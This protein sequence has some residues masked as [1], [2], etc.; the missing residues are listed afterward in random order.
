ML[1]EFDSYAKAK[2]IETHKD[3][4][5]DA[6]TVVSLLLKN[7]GYYAYFFFH[8]G[9][10]AQKYVRA[11]STFEWAESDPEE[12]WPMF[13]WDEQD[14]VDTLDPKAVWYD[15]IWSFQDGHAYEELTEFDEGNAE[16]VME[17]AAGKWNSSMIGPYI[18]RIGEE[19]RCGAGQF[20]TGPAEVL[21]REF[22]PGLRRD[23][24]H[25]FLEHLTG[26]FGK[27]K[28]SLTMCP[29]ESEIMWVP[30]SFPGAFSLSD[31]ELIARVH[32]DLP[33]VDLWKST[34]EQPNQPVYI[35][36]FSELQLQQLILGLLDLTGLSLSL[37]L[38][39]I[40]RYKLKKNIQESI[41]SGK[42]FRDLEADGLR[43]AVIPFDGRSLCVSK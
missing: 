5:P 20:N 15:N 19:V 12:T 34:Q 36:E 24:F 25:S 13:I 40:R 11:E 35:K 9:L 30:L 41:K 22:M 27:R 7:P 8:S 16:Y 6:K 32:K 28:I 26:P 14:R 17:H 38:T 10:W 29:V 1:D 23:I 31:K 4:K 37:N 18:S 42:F 3:F 21:A 43:L 2:C 33:V 39:N